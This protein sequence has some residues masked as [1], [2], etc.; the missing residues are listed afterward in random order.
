[1]TGGKEIKLILVV[2]VSLFNSA[3]LGPVGSRR[4][5]V[6]FVEGEEGKEVAGKEGSWWD[7]WVREGELLRFSEQARAAHVF[8]GLDS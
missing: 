6:G 1:M 8:P 3:F 5:Q 2:L 7:W 4:Q